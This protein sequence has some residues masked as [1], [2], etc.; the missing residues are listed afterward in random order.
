VSYGIMQEHGGKM[1][2]ESVVGVGTTF[3][4]EF[5]VTAAAG[6][7]MSVAG[8]SAEIPAAAEST[9]TAAAESTDADTGK[10]RSVV[11]V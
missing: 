8:P 9:A 3:R 1:Q 2:V 10:P 6:A 7:S 5:P 4:L 11:H